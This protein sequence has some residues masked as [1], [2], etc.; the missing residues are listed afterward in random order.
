MAFTDL[1]SDDEM[2]FPPEDGGEEGGEGST[3][4]EESNNRT[5]IIIAAILGG[6]MLLVLIAIAIF[7][8]SR[9]SGTNN[10]KNTAAAISMLQTAEP[11]TATAAAEEIAA[12]QATEKAKTQA[13]SGTGSGSTGGETTTAGGAG[14]ASPTPT[15]TSVVQRAS[16][17]TAT[18]LGAPNSVTQTV[19]ALQTQVAQAQKTVIP[20][21]TQL[22][23]TGFADDVGLPALFGM[24]VVLIIVIFLARRLRSA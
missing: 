8:F 6:I 3:P 14:G 15:P 11:M 24:A 22:P 16:T 17:A 10:A 19:S 23:N 7:G 4:P 9:M 12:V 13:S 20:T 18:P 21:S 2:D 5:F 1:N